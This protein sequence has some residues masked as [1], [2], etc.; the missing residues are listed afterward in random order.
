VIDER[1]KVR[2]E[3]GGFHQGSLFFRDGSS[4]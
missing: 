4:F 3:E 2:S 1:A